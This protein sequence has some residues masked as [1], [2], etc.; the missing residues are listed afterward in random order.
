MRN[1]ILLLIPLTLWSFA[2]LS[3]DVAVDGIY[4]DLDKVARKATVTYDKGHKY[5]G[6]VNIPNT[7]TNGGV[8]YDV[9]SIHAHAFDECTELAAV[10]F[11]VSLETIGDF[12]F[13]GCTSLTSVSLPNSVDLIRPFAFAGCTGLMTFLI[14]EKVSELSASLFDGCHNLT[15]VIIPMG[16]KTIDQNAFRDC[17][18]LAAINIPPLMTNLSLYSDKDNR[19]RN[20]SNI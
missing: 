20:R 17:V 14:P 5:A 13:N 15:S 2:M 11:P 1:R 8:N 18:K 12:A 4:Y 6:V 16:V 9:T 19:A 7:I 3:Y 10:T